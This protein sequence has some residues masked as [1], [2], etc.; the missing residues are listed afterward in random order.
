MHNDE[1][2]ESPRF[3][4]WKRRSRFSRGASW[5]IGLLAEFNRKRIS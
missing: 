2:S 4:G 5:I 3:L 1:N